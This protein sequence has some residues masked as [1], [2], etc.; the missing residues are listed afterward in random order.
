MLS[1]CQSVGGRLRDFPRKARPF[2]RLG[3]VLCP[4]SEMKGGPGTRCPC[5]TPCDSQQLTATCCWPA[6]TQ[7]SCT[8]RGLPQGCEAS[9]QMRLPRRELLQRAGGP[10]ARLRS[11]LLLSQ[12]HSPGSC[13]ARLPLPTTSSSRCPAL[14]ASKAIGLTVP[15][16]DI[17]TCFDQDIW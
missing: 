17:C 7:R 10:P 15:G 1:A 2:L 16:L 13:L 11:L 5:D 12:R 4:H 14:Q 8:P 9:P 3:F 6:H